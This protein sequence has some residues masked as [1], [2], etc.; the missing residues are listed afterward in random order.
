MG[1]KGSHPISPTAL[2]RLPSPANRSFKCSSS[3]TSV[4][5]F[6]LL[7]HTAVAASLVSCDWGQKAQGCFLGLVVTWEEPC[8]SLP[9]G[10]CCAGG[11][12][13]GMWGWEGRAWWGHGGSSAPQ[14]W[15][16]A[17]RCRT[18]TAME[19]LRV[20]LALAGMDAAA[21]LGESGGL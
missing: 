6:P 2:T 21:G 13:A 3:V 8:P 4:P 19:L 16:G 10:S 11:A 15:D 18:D 12:S 1:W 20:L 5:Q 14:Q 17:G 9:A 7:H